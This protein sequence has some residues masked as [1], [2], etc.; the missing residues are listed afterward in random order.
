[1]YLCSY[2]HTPAMGILYAL[3]EALA[4]VA[5]EVGNGFTANICYYYYAFIK[6]YCMM[7]QLQLI[8]FSKIIVLIS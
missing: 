6:R 3:R 4:I 5:E 7:T 8:C 2:H 1:M